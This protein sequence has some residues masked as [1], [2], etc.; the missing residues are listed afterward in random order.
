MDL[1]RAQPYIESVS[2]ENQPCKLDLTNFRVQ[3]M[4]LDHR[5]RSLVWSQTREA[6]DLLEREIPYDI[7]PWLLGIEPHSY[8]PGRIIIARSHRY[9][10]LLMPWKQIA[11][12]FKD[13]LLFVGLPEEHD[14]FQQHFGGV[15]WFRTGTLMDVASL[16]KSA[17]LVIANQS[18]PHAVALGMGVP[19][20]S[21]VSPKHPDCVFKRDNIQYC[22][23]GSCEFEDFKVEGAL[24][25]ISKINTSRTPPGR[26]QHGG[27]AFSSVDD[28][29]RRFW[30]ADKTLDPE[31]LR[32]DIIV[33]NVIRLQ[34]FFQGD[35]Q[36]AL[37]GVWRE[38]FVNAGIEIPEPK[39][40]IKP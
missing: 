14:D 11:A 31:K 29:V 39:L 33:E 15:E 28:A 5:T 1:I 17:D 13:R 30:N 8:S 7:S 12:H 34:G 40:S 35:V 38:A 9:R 2:I 24:I 32:Y 4:K 16:M 18:S 37:S 23:S 22:V 6:S 27:E 20:I 3:I 19:L 36:Q 26:W 10:N 21:E 25:D